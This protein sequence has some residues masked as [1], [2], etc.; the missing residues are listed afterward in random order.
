MDNWFA[1]RTQAEALAIFEE[2]EAAAGPVLS[3]Q[4]IETDPHYVARQAV[5]N[6]EG[7]PMQGL[8]ARLSATPGAIKWRGRAKMKTAIPYAVTVGTN[9]SLLRVVHLSFHF[10]P[11]ISLFSRNGD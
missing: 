7:T 4:D 11:S 8:V 3:M 2:I 6:I 10:D 5:V 9:N 1:S